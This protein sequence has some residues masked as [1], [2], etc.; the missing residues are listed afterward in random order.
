MSQKKTRRQDKISWLAQHARVFA[1]KSCFCLIACRDFH[2]NNVGSSVFLKKKR[3]EKKT[4]T[5]L[6]SEK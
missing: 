2:V 5:F 3:K 6:S 1:V 4:I